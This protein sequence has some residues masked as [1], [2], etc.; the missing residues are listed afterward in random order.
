LDALFQAV[1]GW[2]FFLQNV[3]PQVIVNW[4]AVVTSVLC[5]TALFIGLQAFLQWLACRMRSDHGEGESPQSVWQKRWTGAILALTILMFIA[6]ISAVGLVHQ[7]VWLMTSPEPMLVSN[8]RGAVNRMSS[9]NNLKQIALGSLNYQ[10]TYDS[11]PPGATFDSHGNALHGWQTSI[12]PYMEYVELWR[13]ID[14]KVPWDDPRNLSHFQTVIKPYL[15]PGEVAN[16]DSRGLALSYYASNIRLIGG[17]RPRTLKDIPDGTAGT[18]LNGEII[19][20][21]KPW[22][23]PL[24]W[25]D[26]GLGINKDPNGF[27][28]PFRGGANFSFADGHVQFLSD[29]ITPVVLKALSTPD[30]GE[31]IPESALEP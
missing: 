14:M 31:T 30:G 7:T 21:P 5:L 12:L 26:P 3:A 18:I 20:H 15:L 16:T 11:L 22:G 1:F 24:N 25:R 19:S 13:Y 6:G 17:D 29:K 10:Q 4:N 28:S 9:Q 2:A 27:G 8:F 23:H